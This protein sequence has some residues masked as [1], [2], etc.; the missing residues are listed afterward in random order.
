[1]AVDNCPLVSIIT[2]VYN[3]SEFL[4]ELIKSVL[5]QDYPN[6]EHIIIDDGSQDN[7]ATI[8]ILRKYSHLR[9]WSH[10]KQGQYATMNEGISTAQGEFI[11]F[12]SAD[13]IISPGAVSAA[14]DCLSAHPSLDGIF[15]LT[16]FMDSPG[17]VLAYP[18]PFRRAPI[19]FHAYFAHIA[20]CS[21]Y[22]RRAS[23]Q[24]HNL[25]FDS[26]L[27][28]TGDYDWI[29]RISK[30]GLNTR[31]M[32]RELSRVRL[33]QNQT[34]QMQT[35]A[36][37]AERSDVLKKHGLNTASYF[38]LSTVYTLLSRLRKAGLIY[39]NAGIMGIYQKLRAWYTYK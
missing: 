32:K 34:T 11:C 35:A 12:V 28:Y 20:H 27:K 19:R 14:V 7:G 30:S 17:N 13:D 22:I 16:S 9:W 24:R 3:G 26:S 25:Y 6:I 18:L 29:I 5:N 38:L 8:S 1:M 36:C 31:A 2:P 39:K 10:A 33:H 15:G 4:E 21:F 37:K 23:L